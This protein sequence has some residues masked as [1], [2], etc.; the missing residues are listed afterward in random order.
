MILRHLKSCKHTSCLWFWPA[1]LLG[2]L[3]DT[4]MLDFALVSNVSLKRAPRP[5]CYATPT[6]A[7]ATLVLKSEELVYTEFLRSLDL[8]LFNMVFFRLS[9]LTHLRI[10]KSLKYIAE[11]PSGCWRIFIT[12]IECFNLIIISLKTLKNVFLSEGAARPHA[13]W[14]LPQKLIVFAQVFSKT[15]VSFLLLLL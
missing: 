7:S 14:A 4:R 2:A 12:W 15:I 6:E 10:K 1:K 8:N 5:P 11:K 9:K 13:Y 3:C